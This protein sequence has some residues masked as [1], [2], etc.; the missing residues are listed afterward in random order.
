MDGGSLATLIHKQRKTPLQEENIAYIAT[1]LLKGLSYLHSNGK[2]H[3][4]VRV[5]RTYILF[6]CRDISS[7]NTLLS[8]HGECKI[9]GFGFNVH[10][11]T[12]YWIAPEAIVSK[13][14]DHKVLIFFVHS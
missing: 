11:N 10:E 7:Y 9:G 5:M 13:E 1:C 2:I 8:T 14:Y 6:F 4:L 12:P 3:R